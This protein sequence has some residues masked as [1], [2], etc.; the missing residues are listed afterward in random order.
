MSADSEDDV[1]LLGYDDLDYPSLFTNHGDD[2]GTL[3]SE[4]F[5]GG[6]G[7][8]KSR[9]ELSVPGVRGTIRCSGETSTATAD[10]AQHLY[11]GSSGRLEEEEDEDMD[12]HPAANCAGD[13]VRQRLNK[14]RISSTVS[15]PSDLRQRLN[16]RKASCTRSPAKDLRFK[17]TER[18]ETRERVGRDLRQILG[19]VGESAT[20]P[21]D[22][23]QNAIGVSDSETG[24][25]LRQILNTDGE[26]R[27]VSI[28]FSEI[29]AKA[30]KAKKESSRRGEGPVTLFKSIANRD[31][32]LRGATKVGKSSTTKHGQNQYEDTASDSSASE[33]S[34][35]E[36]CVSGSSSL[37]RNSPCASVSDHRLR[38]CGIRRTNSSASDHQRRGEGGETTKSLRQER[39]K[40]MSD[41]HQH[42]RKSGGGN[43]GGRSCRGSWG[44]R[45]DRGG[46]GSTPHRKHNERQ[47]FAECSVPSRHAADKGPSGRHDSPYPNSTKGETCSHRSSDDSRRRKRQRSW[48]SRSSSRQSEDRGRTSS[49]KRRRLSGERSDS[50]ARDKLQRG[51]QQR[52]R[53]GR[54]R[55]NCLGRQESSKRGHHKPQTSRG[56]RPDGFGGP[57]GCNVAPGPKGS[58]TMKHKQASDPFVVFGRIVSGR[59]FEDWNP[60]DLCLFLAQNQDHLLRALL[61]PGSENREVTDKL[62]FLLR[63]ALVDASALCSNSR[64]Q[65]MEVL[66]TSAFFESGTILNMVKSLVPTKERHRDEKDTGVVNQLLEVVGAMVSARALATEDTV[67]FLGSLQAALRAGV[68]EGQGD[69]SALPL[70]DKARNVESRAKALQMTFNRSTDNSLCLDDVTDDSLGPI[71]PNI[72]DIRI[73][74]RA[75]FQPRNLLDSFPSATEYIR[76]IFL[77]FR[78]DFIGP[79]CQGIRDYIEYASL[80]MGANERKPRF[81][82]QD[83][84]LY[85]NV[86][87]LDTALSSDT[88]V[89]VTIRIDSSRI[90]NFNSRLIYGSLVCLSCDEFRSVVYATVSYR[91]SDTFRHTGLLNVH[92]LDNRRIDDEDNENI[93]DDENFEDQE[94]GEVT[95]DS[96]ESTARDRETNGKKQEGG[97]GDRKR[98]GLD[99]SQGA[100]ESGQSS[101]GSLQGRTFTMLESTAFYTAYVHTLQSLKALHSRVATRQSSLPFSRQLLQMKRTISPPRCHEASEG[102]VSFRCMMKYAKPT[103]R[104]SVSE[105][106]FQLPAKRP[107]DSGEAHAA[108]SSSVDNNEEGSSSVE[109]TTP[110]SLECTTKHQVEKT[111]PQLL[112]RMRQRQ[113]ILV[114]ER[115]KLEQAHV[116][117][118][119]AKDSNTLAASKPR[120]ERERERRQRINAKYNKL[121]DQPHTWPSAEELGL[122]DSQY[123]ALRLALTSEVA[124]IQGPPGT[125]KTTLGIRI[126][127]LLLENE[128]LWRKDDSGLTQETPLLLLSYTNHALD[129]F[130]V[131][132]LRLPVLSG[133]PVENV[134]RVGSRSE[135]DVLFQHTINRQRQLLSRHRLTELQKDRNRLNYLRKSREKLDKS[136]QGYTDGIVD[137]E[138]FRRRD[139]MSDKHYKALGKRNQAYGLPAIVVWLCLNTHDFGR[140]PDQDDS[141][142]HGNHGDV[143]SMMRGEQTRR[144]NESS[145]TKKRK[146]VS[147]DCVPALDERKP[148]CHGKDPGQMTTGQKN[149]AEEGQLMDLSDDDEDKD[150]DCTEK[151]TDLDPYERELELEEEHRRKL[152]LDEASDEEN[153]VCS[154]NDTA[155]ISSI[156]DDDDDSDSQMDGYAAAPE[157][158][159]EKVEDWGEVTWKFLDIMIQQFPREFLENVV[160]KVQHEVNK[161]GPMTD[162]EE[163]N[164]DDL[165]R[166]DVTQRWRLYR[167]W[168][169]RIIYPLQ[170]QRT[171]EEEVFRRVSK[172]VEELR[173]MTDPRTMRKAR[174][175]AMTTTGAARCAAV[176]RELGARVVLVEEA[177]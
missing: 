97:S 98:I 20:E 109:A 139:V 80:R 122:D 95:N 69:D 147:G 166:L 45:S 40:S 119:Q 41:N 101:A 91:D 76:Y 164:V 65:L 68:A 36:I 156:K 134:I 83:V 136:I 42:T 146:G 96:L 162:A 63:T 81:R 137:H 168:L 18:S 59:P 73:G 38:H 34:N 90:Q 43:R 86:Y 150:N 77:S 118:I 100:Q 22:L 44:D 51:K 175:V 126:A 78:E 124:L 29:I 160:S 170:Q 33:E 48:R 94:D 62:I 87:V 144:P 10:L 143:K 85:E 47:R 57:G 133:D 104:D 12:K 92:I 9:R 152:D 54:F 174:A 1:L 106:V 161:D 71:L 84:R 108:A 113:H 129:Q 138:F 28:C 5:R 112:D 110:A 27:T 159:I 16:K 7:Y 105:A 173:S 15:E 74:R 135:H 177:A 107:E 24:L 88:G 66:K 72:R 61:D 35:V 123:A 50:Q 55:H 64:Q 19:T 11:N 17:L 14:R 171:R 89:D 117:R 121:V 128:N 67:I 142:V 53:G 6:G 167:L 145:A 130:L 79:L 157:M 49:P 26:S 140:S 3:T 154:Q 37:P 158:A 13:D 8:W 82:N 2:D 155:S 132:L 163:S 39:T 149:E 93:D 21:N 30:G 46:R 103:A 32:V 151:D 141:Y 148:R 125:G 176:L 102:C 116:R 56:S 169:Q 172:R 25:H 60:D 70:I 114:E 99:A 153:D 23:R 58:K 75:N 127:E 31:Q 120:E 4:E 165:W 131:E 115:S 111:V 52:Q